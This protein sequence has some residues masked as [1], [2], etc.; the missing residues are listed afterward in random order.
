MSIQVGALS[1]LIFFFKQTK[2]KAQ[3]LLLFLHF[4]KKLKLYLAIEISTGLHVA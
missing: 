4:A 1:P 3:V 2:G